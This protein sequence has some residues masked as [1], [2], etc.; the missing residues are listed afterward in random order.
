M[1]EKIKA[2]Q[3]GEEIAKT[4]K[5]YVED[6]KVNCQEAAEE[7]AINTV[8][9]LKENS[10]ERTKKYKKNWRQE[11]YTGGAIVYQKA[12]TYR[13]THL[14]EK[15]WQKKNGGR[16]AAQPHIGTAEEG[17]VKEYEEKLIRRLEG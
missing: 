6:I 2:E 5:Q 13:L 9:K 17:A 3:L 4:L 15:G 8:A 1:S 7:V 14:L 16:V 12:P 11:S 10:P